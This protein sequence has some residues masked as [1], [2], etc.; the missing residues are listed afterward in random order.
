M[1]VGRATTLERPWPGDE[2]N[3]AP[4]LA[5]DTGDRVRGETCD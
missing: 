4:T 3:D 1:N 2:T 5:V